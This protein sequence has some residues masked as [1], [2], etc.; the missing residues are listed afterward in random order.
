METEKTS[1]IYLRTAQRDFVSKGIIAEIHFWYKGNVPIHKHDYYEF[2]I[3]TKGYILHEI[4]GK[5]HVLNEKTFDI[6][7]PGEAHAITTPINHPSESLNVSI[8][9]NAMKLL[10]E[11]FLLNFE[12]V[13][14]GGVFP[15]FSLTEQQFNFVLYLAS[16]I[17]THTMQQALPY[18][19]MVLLTILVPT[20]KAE[21]IAKDAPTWFT[22]FM[23]TLSI[24]ETFVK[25]VKEIYKSAPTNRLYLCKLFKKQTGKTLVSYV[26]DKKINYACGLLA[27]TNYSVQYISAMVSYESTAHFCRT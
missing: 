8:D 18:I 12:K 23:Q 27:N 19:Q 26:T 14:R 15:T 3:V 11:N 25:P 13:S 22:F 16:I 1:D 6:I 4:D 24:P 9:K 2:V 20:I 5:E 17:N 21:D 10:C 7:K